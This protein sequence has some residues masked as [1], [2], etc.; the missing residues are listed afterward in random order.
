MHH[1]IY[2]LGDE[3]I[4]NRGGNIPFSTFGSSGLRSSKSVFV[5]ILSHIDVIITR[6]NA[7]VN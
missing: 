3:N 1:V 2:S 7:H 5:V 6:L 4:L